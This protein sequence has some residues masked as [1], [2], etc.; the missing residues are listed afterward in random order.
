VSG[1]GA[2][3]TARRVVICAG[4]GGVGKT[5]ISATV[6]LGLAA[7]GRR[8]AVVTIDPARRLAEALGLAELGNQP[9][10]VDLSRFEEAGLR[11]PGE[12]SAMMLDVKRTFDEL[13]GHLAPDATT[14]ESIL[15]NPIYEHLSRAVAGSQE[16]TAV[17]KLFELAREATYDV[18]VLDTPPSRNAIDFLD[19][20]DRL[21]AFFEGRAMAAFLR[22][23]GPVARAA[24]VVFAALRRITG[25]GL[26]DDLSTFFTLIGRLLD[27]LRDRARGVQELLT[28]PGTG[29]LIITSTERAPMAEAIHFAQ[30]LDRLGMRRAGLIV[31]RVQPL[32]ASEPSADAAA[33]RTRVLGD[34][35]AKKVAKTDAE[36]QL[37]ARRDQ[38]S[39]QELRI[40]LGEPDPVWLA[41]RDA[42]LR[43]VLGLVDL[44]RELFASNAE[45]K[46]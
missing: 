40:A 22:P 7:R 14:Q 8:V 34:S 23:T 25:V 15:A 38:A 27:G 2:S 12:L 24:G 9:Q 39:L 20:P 4:A 46:R 33:R 44:E 13:I 18:I 37:L 19:A 6:A 43:D 1:L 28:E 21:T 41:D 26:L 31:N 29:F 32:H 36:V 17:A 35:L 5:T 42:D 3:L 45:A 11:V 30:E 10:R 16:Y